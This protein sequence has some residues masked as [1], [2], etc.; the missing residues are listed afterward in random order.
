MLLTG[1][2]SALANNA[3]QHPC[4]KHVLTKFLRHDRSQTFYLLKHNQYEQDTFWFISL[5]MLFAIID[6]TNLVV[7]N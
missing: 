7:K 2:N 3:I 5:S 6:S 4:P 1:I